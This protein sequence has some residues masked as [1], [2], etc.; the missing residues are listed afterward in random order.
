MWAYIGGCG[1]ERLKGGQKIL[2]KCRFFGPF[3]GA[4]KL[5]GLVGELWGGEKP[6]I[7]LAAFGG[8][9]FAS[10]QHNTKTL[11]NIGGT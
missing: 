4:T 11:G 9:N 6:R 8:Q 2:W 7:S 1:S 10:L 3:E 5:S